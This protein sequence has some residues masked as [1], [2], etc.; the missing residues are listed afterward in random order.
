MENFNSNF[1]FGGRTCCIFEAC[2]YQNSFLCFP[3]TDA[4]VLN[5]DYDHPDYFHSLDEIKE[6]FQSYIRDAKRVFINCDDE[7]CRELCHKNI[8]TFGFNECATYRAELCS[9]EETGSDKENVMYNGVSFNV[10]KQG[11]FL[12][13]CSL[14][15][16]GMHMVYNAL[17]AFAI[18]HCAQVPQE[19]I[20][21]AL[22]TFKGSR[23]RMELLKKNDTG[24]DIFVDYAHHPTEIKA[25]LSAL[26]EKGYRDV[27]CVFQAH[28]FSRTHYLYDRFTSSFKGVKELIIAPTFSAREENIFELSEEKFAIDCGGEFISNFEKIAHRVAKTNCDCVVLMG[29]GDLSAKLSL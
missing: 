8:I 1:K 17:C 16:Y 24:A 25:T 29:A 6:S 7:G 22:S 27:L 4:V 15:Y 11:Q 20:A 18:S 21:Y 19:K 3:K 12:C 9:K 2:E 23:Q 14:P 28:T 10:Y 5:I 13:K 26:F